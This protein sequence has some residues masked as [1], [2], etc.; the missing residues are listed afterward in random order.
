MHESAISTTATIKQPVAAT[1]AVDS[2]FGI[3][4]DAPPEEEEAKPKPDLDDDDLDDEDDDFRRVE[5]K[6]DGPPSE[7][8]SQPETEEPDDEPA[9][10]PAPLPAPPAPAPAARPMELGIFRVLKSGL[11]G[12]KKCWVCRDLVQGCTTF[13][14]KHSHP[15]SSS[16]RDYSDIHSWCAPRLSLHTRE[17][18]MRFISAARVDEVDA[19]IVATLD[20]L[21]VESPPG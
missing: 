3:A 4:F 18:D 2:P 10:P 21:V 13:E 11:G 6:S 16:F 20:N 12:K 9:A 14:H 19:D 1:V 17:R 15:N 8:D 5:V 7:T